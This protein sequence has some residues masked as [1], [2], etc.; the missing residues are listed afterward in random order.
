MFEKASK[1]KLRFK[2]ENGLISTEDLWDMNLRSL[3]TLAKSLNR[4]LKDNEE[5][6]IEE[7]SKA[8]N[9]DEL[10][11]DIVKHVI[12]YK[13]VQKQAADDRAAK[14]TRKKQILEIIQNKQNEALSSMSLED[15]AKELQTL[16]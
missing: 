5:S 9:E 3:D 13:L 1:L 2:V 8:S 7:K 6:F 14:E 10:R 11:F 4:K 16:D 12:Q 15:L